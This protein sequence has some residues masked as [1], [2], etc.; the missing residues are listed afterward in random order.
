MSAEPMVISKSFGHG[1]VKLTAYLPSQR[2]GVE[3]TGENAVMDMADLFEFAN[4]IQER[5]TDV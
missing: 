2:I 4:S 3:V 1:S 5:L